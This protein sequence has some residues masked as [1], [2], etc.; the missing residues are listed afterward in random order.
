V[1]QKNKDKDT[2]KQNLLSKAEFRIRLMEYLTSEH[3]P[4]YVRKWYH[5]RKANKQVV[6]KK[7]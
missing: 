5:S 2:D 7:V 3:K 4:K 6:Y 1:N